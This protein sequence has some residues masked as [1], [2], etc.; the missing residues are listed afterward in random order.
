MRMSPALL[1]TAMAMPS[2][3]NAADYYK[4][5]FLAQGYADVHN[6]DDGSSQREFINFGES[7]FVNTDDL[8]YFF[9]DDGFIETFVDSSGP[10]LD[11]GNSENRGYRGPSYGFI[12]NLGAV[13]TTFAKVT[14]FIGS[15]T[16]PQCPDF[17]CTDED[18]PLQLAAQKLDY[19]VDT[20]LGGRINLSPVPEPVTWAMM[21]AGVGAVGAA[22]RRRLR[23]RFVEPGCDRFA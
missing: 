16:V 22:M 2:A 5:A 20:H 21:V 7:I 15:Y 1:L 23:L 3:A 13:T 12:L 17:S 10:E 18:I 8:P 11:F 6:F 19:P 14:D 9:G 4:I